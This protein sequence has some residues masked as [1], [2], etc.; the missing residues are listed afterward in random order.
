[1]GLNDVWQKSEIDHTFANQVDMHGD[2]QCQSMNGGV[3]CLF[4]GFPSG[5]GIPV[6]HPMETFYDINDVREVSAPSLRFYSEHTFRW[7]RMEQRIVGHLTQG[8]PSNIPRN[9]AFD[10]TKGSFFPL[11]DDALIIF[12]QYP[13]AW[14]TWNELTLRFNGTVVHQYWHAH[15]QYTTDMWLLSGTAS[16]IGLTS[17]TGFV[18]VSKS[19]KTTKSVMWEIM[20]TVRRAHEEYLANSRNSTPPTI[21]CSLNL[22]RWDIIDEHKY[23]RYHF[24]HCN[25]WTFK[26]GQKITVVS[27]F[28]A[29]P[30]R[31]TKKIWLHTVIY[32]VYIV[33][34][35]IKTTLAHY[36]TW[37]DNQQRS[38][39]ETRRRRV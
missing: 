33:D 7:T 12:N 15:H 36:A 8:V 3:D 34:D 1:M 26:S 16:N 38:F 32:L 14:V 39:Q 31:A 10:P 19:G 30:Q 25:G 13:T 28:D 4:Q 21:L 2:R 18:N 17:M 9:S 22:D 6:L 11:H 27:F 5:F 20:G 35:D 37:T 24:P 23:D 29:E